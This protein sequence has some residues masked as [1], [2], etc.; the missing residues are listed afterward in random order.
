[1]TPPTV[2]RV[3]ASADA[4]ARD[5]RLTHVQGLRGVAVL[6]VVLYHAGLPLS[7]GFVGVDVFFVISGFVITLALARDVDSVGKVRFTRFYKRR[8]RRLLPALALVVVTTLLVSAALQ[9]P[10]GAQQETSAAAVGAST[11]SANVV[12][13]VISGDY[14][15]NAAETIPLL[16]T[17]SLAVEEQFYL[18]FPLT[19]AL[20]V[21]AGR[22][23]RAGWMPG[24]ALLLTLG[25]LASFMLSLYLSSGNTL[26]GVSSPESAA[27]Y[28]SPTRA[29]QF[30]VGVLV[31]LWFLKRQGR[32]AGRATKAA[33]ILAAG[34]LVAAVVLI[35]AQD[36]F[37][38][39]AALLP[40]LAAAF[41]VAFGS[42]LSFLTSRPLVKVGDLSYSW[43]LWHWPFIV[44]ANA[45]LPGTLTKVIAA[46]A[47]LVVAWAAY[48]W[49]EEPIRTRPSSS[50][51]TRTL[52]AVC[53]VVPVV[54]SGGLLAG[55][56]MKWW[57]DDLRAIARQVEPDPVGRDR[58]CHGF[59][60]LKERTK[61]C[62][63][64][65][66]A[67]QLVLLG[68]SNGAQYA[69][70]AVGAASGLGSR[71]VLGTAPGCPMIDVSFPSSGSGG[72]S[73]REFVT[74]TMEWLDRQ[75]PSV[76]VIANASE[77][78]EMPQVTMAHERTSAT[79]PSQ[80]ESLWREGLQRILT[81]VREAGH[82]PVLLSTS[83]HF[84]SAEENT[85]WNPASCLM[86]DLLLG[87]EQCAEHMPLAEA[88][89]RQARAL[90]S[91]RAASQGARAKY[92]DLRREICSQGT[93]ST[94]R[95]K[96]WVYRDGLHLSTI[97]SA[98]LV[99]RWE[100]LLRPAFTSLAKEN[101][102]S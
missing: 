19:L 71:T 96:N 1:M 81:R 93:C 66:G 28:S 6:S 37:P 100:S 21:W 67:N 39:L 15:A 78:I 38:G 40:T 84:G 54:L 7:G 89:E 11:W 45:A 53:V 41:L 4:K 58:G 63:F 49:V 73:C 20:A 102:R 13:Y 95:G 24:A 99:P 61:T 76:V 56:Q 94:R 8:F 10:F 98:Q 43:Y 88:D 77:N 50:R 14:F 69:E 90:R 33:G 91:E 5:G 68:D 22:R 65:S 16:H 34:A 3:S 87:A 25:G 82:Q 9:S 97:Y 2:Q 44:F 92:V 59:T 52:V 48:T 64:G 101:S 17:W 18:V 51:S 36:P 29:W 83:P 75:P 23:R 47:S 62:T 79:T 32:P 60:P 12:F 35:S 31:A 55:S 57:N 46:A 42:Q 80:K 70:A 85:W 74:E 30:I 27:F 26:P 86:P 72:A